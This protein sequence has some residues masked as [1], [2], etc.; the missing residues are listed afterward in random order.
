LPL[1]VLVFLTNIVFYFKAKNNLKYY[2][3]AYH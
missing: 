1:S 2:L 3:N